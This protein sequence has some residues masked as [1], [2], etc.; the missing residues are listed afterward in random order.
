MFIDNYYFSVNIKDCLFLEFD[1]PHIEQPLQLTILSIKV[2]KYKKVFFSFVFK[3]M[4]YPQTHTHRN[5]T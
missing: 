5:L 4:E 1:M 2:N 3:V